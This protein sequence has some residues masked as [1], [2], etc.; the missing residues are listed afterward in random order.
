MP[1]FHGSAAAVTL[2]IALTACAMTDGMPPAQFSGPDDSPHATPSVTISPTP[3]QL[4]SLIPTAPTG[5]VIEEGAPVNGEDAD[6]EF[7]LT[8]SADQSHYRA[9]QLMDVSAT[10][11]YVG[12]NAGTVVGGSGTGLVGFALERKEDPALRIEP[13]GTSDCRQYRMVRGVAVAHPFMKTGGFADEDPLAA[14][15]RAYFASP[16]LRL[17]AG[18]WTISAVAK[19]LGSATC[20]GP[21]HALSASVTVIVEP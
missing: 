8:I 13:A 21:E 2:A 6:Q 3:D 9:G 20:D 18:T 19:F 17:P 1:S 5:P 16:E 15:Y 12:P 7:R 14:F 11:T 4:A 10:L